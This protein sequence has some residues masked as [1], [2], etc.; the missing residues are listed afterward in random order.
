MTGAAQKTTPTVRD[1]AFQMVVTTHTAMVLPMEPIMTMM[2]QLSTQKC[3]VMVKN[4]VMPPKLTSNT[5]LTTNHTV[6]FSTL[7]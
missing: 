4:V 1:L 2:S 5:S 7:S 3:A 6:A